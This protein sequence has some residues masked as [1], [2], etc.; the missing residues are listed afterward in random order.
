MSD[1]TTS[2]MIAGP[3]NEGEVESWYFTSTV[4]QWSSC[5]LLRIPWEMDESISAGVVLHP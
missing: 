2:A 1:S 3:G 5:E 4:A